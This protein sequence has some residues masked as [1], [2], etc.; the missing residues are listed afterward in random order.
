MAQ[1]KLVIADPLFR[2]I[3][4]PEVRFIALPSESF[5]GRLYREQIPNLFSDFQTFLKEVL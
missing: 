1:A 5:S 2:P 3:C 4:P